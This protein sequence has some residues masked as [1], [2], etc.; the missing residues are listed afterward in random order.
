MEICEKYN[1]SGTM[2]EIHNKLHIILKYFNIKYIVDINTFI[3]T[4]YITFCIEIGYVWIH[5]LHPIGKYPEWY[6]RVLF[7][8]NIKDQAPITRDKSID[9][10][11]TYKSEIK[12]GL[13]PDAT[14]EQTVV[15]LKR[16]I[17]LK[18]AYGIIEDKYISHII[19][20][21][22]SEKTRKLA[23]HALIKT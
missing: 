2:R 13:H 19:T 3:C 7:E 5:I 22:D 16:F 15:A 10:I 12:T 21:L 6:H 8:L 18:Y 11:Q 4:E 20:L 17:S 1:V 9:T 23:M 14:T